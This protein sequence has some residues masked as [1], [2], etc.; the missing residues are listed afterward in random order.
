M[1][2]TSEPDLNSVRGTV[3]K[4]APNRLRSTDQVKKGI[5][6]RIDCGEAPT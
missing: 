3:R 2:Q 6:V 4:N 5:D 1:N